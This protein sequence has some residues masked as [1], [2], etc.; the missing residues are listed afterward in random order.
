MQAR[1]P[2][3]HVLDRSSVRKRRD[4]GERSKEIELDKI[5]HL[6]HCY[7]DLTFGDL[8]TLVQQGWPKGRGKERERSGTLSSLIDTHDT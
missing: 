6:L 5:G 3:G 7:S 8:G 2:G 4:Q 1:L